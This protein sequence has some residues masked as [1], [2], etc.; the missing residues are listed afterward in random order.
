MFRG[1]SF[2]EAAYAGM[3]S[4]S[5]Q[6]TVVGDPL[7]RPFGTSPEQLQSRL[8]AEHSKML[9]WSFLRLANLGL[10]NGKTPGEVASLM[11]NV[12]VAK[13]SP[14]LQEKLGDLYTASGKPASA[15][16]AYEQAL[17]LDPPP[18]QKLR[19][20][21]TVSEK[22]IAASEDAQAYAT[23]ETILQDFPDYP[24]RAAIVQKMLPIAQKLGKTAEVERL[25]GETKK[26]APGQK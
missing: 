19:L 6:T 12:E 9:E 15:L 26:A 1:F 17:K 8:E 18:M 20:L 5:W 11:E 13:H 25:E 22:H 23:L 2:A 4:V 24:D 7:Y 3:N 16:H 10:M 14:V 21:L